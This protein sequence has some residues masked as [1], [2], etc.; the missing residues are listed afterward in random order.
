MGDAYETIRFGKATADEA[1]KARQTLEKFSQRLNCPTCK[2]SKEAK[3]KRPDGTGKL[4]LRACNDCH[5]MGGLLPEKYLQGLQ[6]RV[7]AERREEKEPSN[8]VFA[9]L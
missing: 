2:G 9:Q 5:G 7:A 1:D 3:Q 6:E 8:E 4:K